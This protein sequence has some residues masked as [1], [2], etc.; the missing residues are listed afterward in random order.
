MQY[1][2]LCPS[3]G[4]KDQAGFLTLGLRDPSCGP[5]SALTVVF[6]WWNKHRS[7]F[8]A[9]KGL[10]FFK[11]AWGW[12]VFE[13]TS[14]PGSTPHSDYPDHVSPA[15]PY[16]LFKFFVLKVGTAWVTVYSVLGISPWST[17]WGLVVFL[18]LPAVGIPVLSTR[19]LCKLSL[20]Y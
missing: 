11:Q 10:V 12:A 15:R 18:A 4:W 17:S 6:G 8:F 7:G 16:L 1:H 3:L 5:D 2:F 13:G 14:N 19:V 9:L 20:T